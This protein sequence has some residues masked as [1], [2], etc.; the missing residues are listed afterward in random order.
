[1]SNSFHPDQARCFVGPDLDPNC[2]QRLSADYISRQRVQLRMVKTA[3]WVKSNLSITAQISK[4]FRVYHSNSLPASGNS[5]CLLMIFANS[6][7]QDQGQQNLGSNLHPSCVTIWCYSWKTSKV[8][9][10]LQTT[11]KIMKN[12]PACKELIFL[13]LNQIIWVSSWDFVTISHLW[14]HSLNMHVQLSSGD[15]GLRFGQN[16]LPCPYVVPASNDGSGKTAVMCR[17]IR[18]FPAK[19][20]DTVKPV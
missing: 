1:M 8:E 17:L 11:T 6:F 4:F 12:Y 16:I 3:K 14:G 9:K 15:R 7:D 20:W 18:D 19:I 2:L 10:Y 13:A 5:C